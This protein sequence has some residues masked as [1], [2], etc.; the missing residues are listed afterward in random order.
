MVIVW[1]SLAA[2][3]L[4]AMAALV[5]APRSGPDPTAPQ[6]GVSDAA[7]FVRASALTPASASGGSQSGAP[8]GTS[9]TIPRTAKALDADAADSDDDD[10]S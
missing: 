9:R 4:I 6:P 3:V 2:L 5:A 10:D 7:G 1:V 8:H